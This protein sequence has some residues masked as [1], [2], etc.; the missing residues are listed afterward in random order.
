MYE[1][2]FRFTVQAASNEQEATDMACDYFCGGDYAGLVTQHDAE[3][4]EV[5]NATE[6]EADKA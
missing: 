2:I 4:R 3:V 1:V 6:S 5:R